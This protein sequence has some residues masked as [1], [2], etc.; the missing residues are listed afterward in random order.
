MKCIG[1]LGGMSWESSAYYYRLLNEQ[2]KE[3]LGGLHSANCLMYSVDFHLIEQMQIEGRWAEA[4]L[5]LVECAK[6]LEHGGARAIL[7]CTNTMH[8]VFDIIQKEVG[9]PLIHIADA[10]AEKITQKR[11]RKIGLLGTIFTMEQE[12]YRGRIE[13]KGIEVI[14]PNVDQRQEINRIIYQELC[15]GIVSSSSRQ[16]Y[17]EAISELKARGAQGVILGCTEIGLLINQEHCDIPIFDTTAI[18]AQA[19]VT[20]LLADS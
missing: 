20:W 15:L 7:L 2:V 9:V 17:Q 3:Q 4:G 14:V 6:K 10:T 16:C 1:L 19:G 5:Y 11:I 8:K 12:F 13:Q 18:H